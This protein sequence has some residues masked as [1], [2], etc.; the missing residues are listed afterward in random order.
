MAGWRAK[1]IRDAT[2]LA[3][4]QEELYQTRTLVIVDAGVATADNLTLLRDHG[5]SYLVNDSRKHRGR[6]HPEFLVW[7]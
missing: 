3:S 2:N 5:F 6:Y 7:V 1:N 4:D